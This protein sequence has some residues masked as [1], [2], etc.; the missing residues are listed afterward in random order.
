M[1]SEQYRLK[2]SA[3]LEATKVAPLKLGDSFGHSTFQDEEGY[4]ASINW[5]AST[6][7]KVEGTGPVI[8]VM[9]NG[10]EIG[11]ISIYSNQDKTGYMP[12]KGESQLFTPGDQIAYHITSSGTVSISELAI[13]AVF[14]AERSR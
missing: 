3:R 7:G 6:I 5:R 13:T 10:S 1:S 12:K 4:L 8:S 14:T 2:P 11:E 9:R